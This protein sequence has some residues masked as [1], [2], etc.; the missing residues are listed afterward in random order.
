I[1]AIVAPPSDP[2]TISP[3]SSLPQ[4]HSNPLATAKLFLDFDGHWESSWGSF[5]NVS[6]PAFD[7]D[8]NSASFS[9]SELASIDE[10]WSRVAEDYAPFN[11]DVTTVDPGTQADRVA[12]VIAIG[13][14]SSDWYGASAGGVAYVGGFYNLSSNVGF[15]F[16]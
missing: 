6:T 8:G 1:P 12:A 16:A 5:P 14:S 4:L 10:I 3:L 15:V 13:G 11:I 9:A 2:S 7:Q